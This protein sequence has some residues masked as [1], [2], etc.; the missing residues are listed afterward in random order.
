MSTLPDDSLRNPPIKQSRPLLFDMVVR[1]IRKELR[2]D[3]YRTRA[4]DHARC[5]VAEKDFLAGAGERHVKKSSLLFIVRALVVAFVREH[6]LFHA[7]NEHD[8]E[9]E[10]LG[11]VYGHERHR[12]GF[13]FERILLAQVLEPLHPLFASLAQ[14]ILDAG[15]FQ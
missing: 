6:S 12:I 1:Y 3:A 15:A 11:S 8:I 10:A 9:F 5:R 4:E 2:G 7:D 13:L 14:I